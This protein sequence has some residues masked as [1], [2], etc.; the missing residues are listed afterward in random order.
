MRVK[1]SN[2]TAFPPQRVGVLYKVPGEDW[3]LNVGEAQSRKAFRASGKTAGK[4]QP[5][6]R[7]EA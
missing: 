5:E 1:P 7:P 2:L 4:G 3:E 6:T